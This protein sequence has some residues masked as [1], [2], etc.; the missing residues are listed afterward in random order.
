MRQ[1]PPPMVTSVAAPRPKF[2]PRITTTAACSGIKSRA[3]WPSLVTT[4]QSSKVRLLSDQSRCMPVIRGGAYRRSGRNSATWPATVS[5]TLI[6]APSPAGEG[7]V[8]RVCA[9]TTPG[10]AS[11]FHSNETLRVSSPKLA[12]NSTTV[13][14]PAVGTESASPG[15]ALRPATVRAVTVGGP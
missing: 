10:T 8:R 14:P 15:T 3:G 1:T 13:A 12:P 4:L 7:N 5:D 6:V 2:E 11:P 9:A